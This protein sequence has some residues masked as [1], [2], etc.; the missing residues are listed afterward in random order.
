MYKFSLS[1]FLCKGRRSG[2][3]S[4]LLL[5]KFLR[6]FDR[7]YLSYFWGPLT[8]FFAFS[9]FYQISSGVLFYFL[10]IPT[11]LSLNHRNSVL[12]VSHPRILINLGLESLLWHYSALFIDTTVSLKHL[13][14]AQDPRFGTFLFFDTWWRL[15][16]YR[17]SYLSE[18]RIFILM[19]VDAVHVL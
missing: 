7:Y 19:H 3:F 16:P 6:A 18:L 8:F 13:E 11:F 17:L 15:L 5:P 12:R 1:I 10:S 9:P 14:F 4:M 2:I